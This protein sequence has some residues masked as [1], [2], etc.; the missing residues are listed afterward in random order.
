MKQQER[1]LE[2]VRYKEP[3]RFVIFSLTQISQIQ[4]TR[5]NTGHCK[6]SYTAGKIDTAIGTPIFG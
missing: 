1:C 5:K 3:H 2:T 4:K 6:Q